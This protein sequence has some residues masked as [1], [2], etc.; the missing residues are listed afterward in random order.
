[1]IPKSGNVFEQGIDHIN[2]TDN[3]VV[4]KLAPVEYEIDSEI[5][6]YES[7]KAESDCE[8]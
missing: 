8:D 3:S 6:G 2:F 1:M 4:P 5:F 7:Y